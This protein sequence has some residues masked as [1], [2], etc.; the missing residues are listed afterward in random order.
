MFHYPADCRQ[1]WFCEGFASPALWRKNDLD[2]AIGRNGA[3]ASAVSTL[4]TLKSSP[5]RQWNSSSPEE[6]ILKTEFWY[7]SRQNCLSRAQASL[8]RSC[9][10]SFFYAL[11]HTYAPH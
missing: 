6:T 3:I 10:D 1:I 7:L 9:C 4:S 8:L 5:R 11:S 2:A